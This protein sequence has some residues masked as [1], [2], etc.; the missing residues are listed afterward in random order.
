MSVCPYN[1]FKFIFNNSLCLMIMCISFRCMQSYTLQRVSPAFWSINLFLTIEKSIIISN[2][3]WRLI[4]FGCV[5]LTRLLQLLKI[6]CWY[7]YIWVSSD[8]IQT[9]QFILT[10]TSFTSQFNLRSAHVSKI[11]LFGAIMGKAAAQ[12]LMLVESW[13]STII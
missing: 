1:S 11:Y 5:R 8:L 10:E 12:Y 6:L 4:L 7:L 9:L 13:L 3:H 2:S